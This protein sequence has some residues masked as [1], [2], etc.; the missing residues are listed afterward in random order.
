MA[1]ELG[2]KTLIHEQKAMQKWE[3]LLM[4]GLG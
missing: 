1:T 4:N 3:M 2:L